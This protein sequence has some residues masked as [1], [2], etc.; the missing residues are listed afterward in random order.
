MEDAAESVPTDSRVRRRTWLWATAGV[1]IA[2]LLAAAAGLSAAAGGPGPGLGASAN[3]QVAAPA[4]SA[5]ARPVRIMICIHGADDGPGCGGVGGSTRVHLTAAQR[6]TAEADSVDV[7]RAISA[8][9]WCRAPDP[10]CTPGNA[11]GVRKVIPGDVDVMRMALAFAGFLQADVWID[12]SL[13][14]NPWISYVVKAG[15]ACIFGS[16]ASTQ[17][18]SRPWVD[19]VRS[20][21]ECR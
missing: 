6:A 15:P 10:A 20:D 19:G 7:L 4:R 18:P 3:P 12:T 2:G 17:G 14:G 9:D 16:L 13:P 1:A 8:I 5:S 21:G 11:T